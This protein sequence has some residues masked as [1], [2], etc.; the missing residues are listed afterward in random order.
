MTTIMTVEA[1]GKDV[2]TMTGT[3]KYTSVMI[4]VTTNVCV[5]NIENKR[6]VGANSRFVT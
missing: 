3:G 1:P 5:V 6:M 2:D 4:V